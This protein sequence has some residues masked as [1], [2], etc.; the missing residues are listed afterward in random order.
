MIH[1]DLN[2]NKR[3]LRRTFDIGRLVYESHHDN[4]VLSL[5]VFS[6]PQL[7]NL[8]HGMDVP[9]QPGKTGSHFVPH[10]PVSPEIKDAG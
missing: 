9:G 4:F 3:L 1:Y 8:L 7:C 10:R 6:A 2:Q 5:V